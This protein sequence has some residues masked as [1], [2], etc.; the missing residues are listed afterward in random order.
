MKITYTPDK[1]NVLFAYD[2]PVEAK[3]LINFPGLVRQGPYFFSPNKKHVVY[4]LYQRLREKNIKISLDGHLYKELM[5][6]F[7][8]KVLPPEF[9]YLTAP[10]E[11]QDIALRFMYTV[12]NSGLLLEPGMGKTKIILD[13]IALMKFVLSVIICPLPLLFVWEDEIN[14]HR[15]DK[16]IYLVETTDMEKEF[17]ALQGHDVVVMN[18]TKAVMMQSM[19]EK[20]KI[21]FLG[22]DEALIKDP[23]TE[24]TKVI[25]AISWNVPHKA[26]MS[27]TLVNNSPLDIFAPVR[28]LEPALTGRSYAKFRE[29]YAV[30]V[31][32]NNV[33]LIVG[34]RRVP[35]IRSILEATSIV[36]TKEEWLK[37]PPKK[38]F[39]RKILM[40][41]EQRKIY[42]FL[43]SN[44]MVEFQGKTI[45]VDNPL[46][47]STKLL[48]IANGFLYYSADPSY[49]ELDGDN[50]KQ[51]KPPRET[52]YFDE[53]PKAD[54]LINLLKTDL[55]GR[56]VMVWY[57]M[58]A[59]RTIIEQKLKAA[60]ISFL[61]I[62]G[63]TKDIR[64][65][66][67]GFN[68]NPEVTILLCQAKS[69]NYGIT[70]LGM[71]L[72]EAELSDIYVAP[73]INPNVF[74]Q[75]FYSLNFSLEVFL[76]QQDRIHRLGQE[77][78]CEYYIL[79]T[80]S[81]IEIHMVK[82]IET[83]Q[84]IRAEMLVDFIKNRKMLLV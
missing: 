29:E 17:K 4:N 40:S 16:S 48:Q 63:G 30:T 36:M 5:E 20:L 12:G 73:G 56:K 6:E 45:E 19:L 55:K 83:K 61:T 32:K 75:V 27:G 25:T 31:K 72:E 46:P 57:N 11:H 60:G 26:I 69:V 76:Q 14:M 50:P 33:P 84:N 8:L 58:S 70:V 24:R 49:V 71:T 13:Y 34:F 42:Q 10:K 53:Q 74:T 62:S 7:K 35:E 9:R 79:I 23:T 64:A 47:L 28:F 67:R 44:Y 22:L 65:K 39:E 2:T 80:N 66:I 18:Y 43:A 78:E 38:F 81:P 41:E 15:H 59:E 37:L 21:N 1:Q 3:L 77:H 68:D 52:L 54:Y 51:V 82:C